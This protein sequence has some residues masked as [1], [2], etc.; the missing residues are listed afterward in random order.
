MKRVL[1]AGTA[2]CMGA[3]MA[4]AEVTVSG[5]GRMGVFSDQNDNLQFHS[6]VRIKF[7]ASAELD[8]GLT[9]GGSIRADNAGPGSSGTGG[10]V[11]LSGPFGKL[12]MGDVDSGAKAAVGHVAEVGYKNHDSPNEI[13]YQRGGAAGEEPALQYAL[14]MMGPVQVYA[15]LGMAPVTDEE[16][17]VIE[18]QYEISADTLAIGAK[19][20]LAIADM[21]SAWIGGGFEATTSDTEDGHLVFGAGADVSGFTGKIVFGMQSRDSIEVDGE[22]VD[23]DRDQ[24]GVSA[25]YSAGQM[26]VTVFYTDDSEFE[27]DGGHEA[28][29]AGFSWNLGGGASLKAGFTNWPGQE[30]GDE[31]AQT[32]DLG[33]TFAF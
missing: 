17:D 32:A 26:G 12:S 5:D 18:G 30:E 2:L 8:N 14:P 29:G 31:D 33:V 22:T 27:G 7:A 6:R 21:G 19:A 4:I 10:D 25:G 15:S 20:D 24:F 9:A 11:Y 13:S 23:Q 28:L 16:G 3:G 1:L